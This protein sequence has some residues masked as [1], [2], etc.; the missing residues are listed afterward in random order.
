MKHVLMLGWEYPPFISGGLGT[1]CEGLSKALS[2]LGVPITFIIP[3]L[4][5]AE[6][7]SHMKLVDPNRLLSSLP[8]SELSAAFPESISGI[9]TIGIPAFLKPY[10]SEKDY[11]QAL[12]SMRQYEDVSGAGVNF[13]ALLKESKARRQV[14]D[15]GPL[16]Y[17]DS[18]F[19]E[20]ARYTA[21]VL[22]STGHINFD[23]IHAHDWMTFPAGVA[24][25]QKTGKP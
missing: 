25:A 10:W 20:V 12:R 15:T 19:E 6:E 7:A 21:L 23:L 11:E 3:H 8:A 18:L 14:I 17:G 4:R 5:G 1:A 9:S 22:S 2:R 13:K 24:L 16:H